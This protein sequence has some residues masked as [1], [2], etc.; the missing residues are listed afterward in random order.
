RGSARGVDI[1]HQKHFAANNLCGT[2]NRESSAQVFPS[3]VTGQADLR[4]RLPRTLQTSGNK[5]EIRVR[6]KQFQCRL[7]NELG[8]VEAALAKLRFVE[9]HRNHSNESTEHAWLV[10]RGL[11]GGN[12]L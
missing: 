1:I 4:L 5:F 7:R 3:L 6:R 9:P 11:K 10:E 2:G 8:L 12:G